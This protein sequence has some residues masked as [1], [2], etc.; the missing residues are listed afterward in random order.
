MRQSRGLQSS[1]GP[2]QKE[3]RP[4][5]LQFRRFETI[6]SPPMSSDNSAVGL[7]LAVAAFV[8]FLLVYR[9]RQ[10]PALKRA[11][12]LGSV[13]GFWSYLNSEA[14]REGVVHDSRQS[15]D[16]RSGEHPTSVRA[17]DDSDQARP[18]LASS[19]IRSR[20][21]RPLFMSYRREDT[22]HAARGLHERL[23]DAFGRDRY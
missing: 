8:L 5:P 12:L 7:A 1:I 11:G 22:A 2:W 19:A 14:A 13:R 6:V 21:A 20:G 3:M 18:K 16:P 15:R 4:S 17:V 10:D 9:V 23:A